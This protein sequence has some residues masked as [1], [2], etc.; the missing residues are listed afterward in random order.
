MYK[1]P[2][3]DSNKNAAAPLSLLDVG[4]CRIMNMVDFSSIWIFGPL[5]SRATPGTNHIRSW[6]PMPQDCYHACLSQFGSVIV[7]SLSL[8]SLY[9]HTLYKRSQHL[10]PRLQQ[11]VS[12]DNLQEA[13]QA[14]PPVLNHI[15]REA[16]REDFAR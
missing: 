7:S 1:A 6:E 9:P 4:K 13:L 3:M 12:D 15:V 16:I 14:F 8:P 2:E 10:A 11:R 5:Q